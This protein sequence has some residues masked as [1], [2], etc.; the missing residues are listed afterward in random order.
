MVIAPLDA[1]PT[2]ISWRA[3]RSGLEDSRL[4]YLSNGLEL[5]HDTSIQRAP[6]Q[7]GA[8]LTWL[9]SASQAALMSEFPY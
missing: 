7:G 5:A 9:L 4:D 8:P 1:I 3:P 2:R 6:M